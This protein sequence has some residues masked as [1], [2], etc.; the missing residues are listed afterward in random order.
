LIDHPGRQMAVRGDV[1][2]LNVITIAII[3]SV[4]VAPSGY[5]RSIGKIK[6]PGLMSGHFL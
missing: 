4:R 5:A 6:G 2:N 3:D 1:L